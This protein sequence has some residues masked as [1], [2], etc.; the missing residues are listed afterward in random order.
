MP[1]TCLARASSERREIDKAV[2]PGEPLRNTATHVSMSPGLLRRKSHVSQIVKMQERR[3]EK[4][5]YS[6]FAE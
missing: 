5:G 6:I 4:P 1:R 2:A 3:E